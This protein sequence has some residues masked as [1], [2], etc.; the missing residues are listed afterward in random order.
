MPSSLFGGSNS[1]PVNVNG[2]IVPQSFVGTEG[3]TL[4]TIT[5]WS[6][7]PGT[8]SLLVFI[9]GD[10]QT[11]NRDFL[12]SSSTTFTLL[13]GVKAG[14]FVDVLGFPQLTLTGVPATAVNTVVN[15]RV[16]SIA[17]KLAD[18]VSVKDLGAV[19]NGVTNDTVNLTDAIN[20]HAYLVWPE[21]TYVVDQLP[22]PIVDSV[23]I[24]YG[25]VVIQRSVS[26]TSNNIVTFIGAIEVYGIT[27]DGNKDV[28]PSPCN[29]VVITGLRSLF[30]R[31]KFI[32]AKASSGYGTGH[33]IIQTTTTNESAHSLRFCEAHD[34]ETDG[35]AGQNV[36]GLEIIGCSAYNNAQNGIQYNNYDITLTQKLFD[37][38]VIGNYVY[39]NGSNGIYFGNSL[40][41]NVL[42]SSPLYGWTSNYESY[43]VVIEGNICRNNAAYG[44]S[45]QGYNLLI[46][47]NICNNNSTAYNWAAGLLLNASNSCVQG[48]MC[49]ANQ[50]GIDAGGS[51]ISIISG[52]YIYFNPVTG[53]NVGGSQ[54]VHVIG[55]LISGNGGTTNP[56][57]TVYNV[58]SDANGIALP[59][60]CQGLTLEGN[61]IGQGLTNTGIVVY[62]GCKDVKVISNTFFGTDL[63]KFLIFIADTGVIANNVIDSGIAR[64]LTVDGAGKVVVPE[65]LDFFYLDSATAVTSLDYYTAQSVVGRQGIA[66]VTVTAGGTGYTGPFN[67]TF[68]GG[69]GSGALG[70]AFVSRGVVIGVRMVSYGTGY[71]SAP[72]P[73]FTAGGGTGA[74]GTAKVGV[75]LL[76]WRELEFYTVQAQ[77]INRLGTPNVE[78]KGGANLSMTAKDAVRL[79]SFFGRWNVLSRAA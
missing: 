38:R 68:T 32:R 77:T 63:S 10:K 21:G 23:W 71:T 34:N 53:L 3:Q 33:I 37:C 79:R 36:H 54:Y 72:T 6:Y 39:S 47:N 58:E 20:N 55:N 75:G 29:L 14:D 27:F 64:L 66:W 67:V 50:F 65:L 76:D 28:N 17:S 73:V 25:N 46:L 45:G 30:E 11:V 35:F 49:E 24:A 44:I 48:N 1:T 4:F 57:I 51:S 12:E 59:L 18:F 8:N 43:R 52:N 78:S 31:C 69:G 13:E 62:D 7:T 2:T 42:I 56:Q 40:A 9:N 19:G 15:G 61:F 22:T 16:R 41:D 70:E 60:L 26:A 5:A 74:T